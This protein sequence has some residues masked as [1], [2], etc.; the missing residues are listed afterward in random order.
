MKNRPDEIQ[1]PKFFASCH[2]RADGNLCNGA[3]GICVMG[4]R[5]SL[6]SN[7]FVG[8]ANDNVMTPLN[9]IEP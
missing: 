7:A 1:V 9:G 2:S 3:Y 5:R 8:G 4:P 6:P